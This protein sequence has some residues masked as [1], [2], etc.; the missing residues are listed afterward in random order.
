LT[1]EVCGG[2][3]D[4]PSPHCPADHPAPEPIG[5]LVVTGTPSD[6]FQFTGWWGNSDEARM[7]CDVELDGTDWWVA[8]LYGPGGQQ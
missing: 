2:A 1:C 6:G 4:K 3:I 5:W 8:P 7:Y